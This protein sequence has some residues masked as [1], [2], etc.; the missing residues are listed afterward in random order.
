MGRHTITGCL[1]MLMLLIVGHGASPLQAGDQEQDVTLA[2]CLK[3]GA[4]TGEFVLVIDE[5][6]THQV[7]AAVEGLELAP[8]LNHRVEITGTLEKTETSSVLKAKALKML[9][10]SCEP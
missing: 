7:Q 9:A 6:V 10:S 1:F 2:G 4:E 8:H 3:A 5:K